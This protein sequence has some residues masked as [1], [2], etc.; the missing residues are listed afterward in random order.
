[1]TVRGIA[2]QFLVDDV[3][4]AIAYYCDQ[5]GF[6]LDFVYDD[7]YSSVSRDGCSIHLKCAPKILADREHRRRHNHLDAY[8]GVTNATAL[9]DELKSRGARITKPVEDQD[10]ACRDFYVEDVDGYILCFSQPLG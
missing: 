6:T 5:L 8:I 9:H 2:P 10:W 7:F 4:R 3:R 1:M